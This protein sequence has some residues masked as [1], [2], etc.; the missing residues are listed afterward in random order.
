ML[1]RVRVRPLLAEDEARGRDVIKACDE[2][3]RQEERHECG[4]EC[5]DFNP[6]LTKSYTGP[7]DLFCKRK[8]TNYFQEPLEFSQN[9]YEEW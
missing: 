6:L 3:V 1:G 9:G 8:I 5:R 4:S 7:M 2:A